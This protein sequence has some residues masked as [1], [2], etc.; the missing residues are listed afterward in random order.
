MLYSPV[1]Q[2]V[3]FGSRIFHGG[4]PSSMLAV[5]NTVVRPALINTLPG[6]EPVNPRT[7]SI[8]RNSSKRRLSERITAPQ[9]TSGTANTVFNVSGVGA[10]CFRFRISAVRCPNLVVNSATLL[11]QSDFPR[12]K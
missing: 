7:I 6:A 1:T 11:K 4:T 5:H 8:G 12:S 2:P 10:Y 3:G 9:E